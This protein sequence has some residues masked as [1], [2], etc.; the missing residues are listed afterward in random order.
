MTKQ[1]IKDL[2]HDKK[3]ALSL[4]NKYNNIRIHTRNFALI[5]SILA[6]FTAFKFGIWY[7]S[8]S[9]AFISVIL[10]FIKYKYKFRFELSTVLLF[11]VNMVEDC[12]NRGITDS[13]EMIKFAEKKVDDLEK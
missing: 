7:I 9:L 4:F 1:E 13:D 6:V 3:Y 12:L 5:F 2:E 8:L 10:L 11:S